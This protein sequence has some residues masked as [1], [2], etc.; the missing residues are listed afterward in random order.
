VTNW[1]NEIGALTKGVFFRF[2]RYDGGFRPRRMLDF[3]GGGQPAPTWPMY[4]QGFAQQPFAQQPFMYQ[5]T[6]PLAMAQIPAAAGAAPVTPIAAPAPAA[7]P[8]RR[9]YACY[10]CGNP[11]HL[12]K[13][14]P[15]L[16]ATQAQK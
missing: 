8:A 10:G 4:N 16:A 13:D 1:V 7:A 2:P 15:L 6:A 11:S 14:C 9:T 3:Y 12:L 5:N